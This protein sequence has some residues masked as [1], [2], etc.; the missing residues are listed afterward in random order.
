MD[1][2]TIIASS[3]FGLS[4]LASAS[5]LV[6]WALRADPRTLANAGRWSVAGLGI[7]AAAALVWLMINGRWTQAMMLAAFV[8]PVLARGAPRWRSLLAPLV[9]RRRGWAGPQLDPGDG[10][11]P[12]R[13]APRPAPADP[14]LVRQS[15]AVLQAYLDQARQFAERP[16]LQISRGSE[17][18]NKAVNGSGRKRMSAE[19]ALGVLGLEPGARPEQ[20]G[21]AHRRLQQRVDPE[22]GG[23]LYLT[24]KID[25]ARDVLLGQRRIGELAESRGEPVEHSEDGGG[26]V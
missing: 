1:P 2:W 5:P 25:E 13:R 4:P 22:L 10:A 21:E 8:M 14:E 26:H 7:A 20:I 18:L 19:E 23:S 17:R 15:I 3:A 6:N 9:L 12:E 24:M 16:P 11:A